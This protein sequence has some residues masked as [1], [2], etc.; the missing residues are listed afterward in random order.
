MQDNEKKEKEGEIEEGKAIQSASTL[1]E[2]LELVKHLEE[3]KL[4]LEK[5][6]AEL[7]NKYL[8]KLAD[9]DNFQKRMK[10][11]MAEFRE[12][13]LADFITRLLEVIDNF[14]RA[15]QGYSEENSESFYQ[16]VLLI[17]RQLKELLRKEGVE[18][19]NMTGEFDP[20][21]HQAVDKEERE[22]IEEV[23]IAEVLQKGY[24]MKGRLLRPA[25]VKVYVP[26]EVKGNGDNGGD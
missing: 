3:E 2:C 19:L 5:E 13:A 8:R 1:E 25:L 23:K 26:K 24:L 22:D 17:Y 18:E 9:F 16:G 6:N 20:N 10:R 12:F 14:E 4:A 15:L 7:L 11:E 21:F